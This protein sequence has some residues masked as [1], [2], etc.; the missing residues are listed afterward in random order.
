ML[1]FNTQPYFDDFDPS[2]NFHRILFKPGY[3]VQARELTQS[4]TIL[5]DQISKFADNIFSQNTPVTGGNVTTN[6]N[7]FYLK[8]NPIYGAV[9]IS[10]TAFLNR[11]IQNSTGTV[12]AKVIAATEATGG[13]P[14]TLVITYFTGKQFAAGD[15]IATA[16]G[17][18]LYANIAIDTG[19]NNPVGKSSTASISDGVFYVVN[20]YSI[21]NTQNAD[22]S[23]SQ[24]SIGNFVAVQ[25]QTIILD[26]YDSSPSLR[27]GLQITETVY[28]YVNDNSLLDPAVGA[29]NYQAPGA[30]RYVITLSLVT[31]PLTVGNDQGFIELVRIVNGQIVKQV[32]S[33][34]YSVID[35]YFAKRD[36]ETNGD[37]IVNDFKLT[38]Y[39]NTVNSNQYDLKIGKGIAYVRGYRI[40]NQSDYILTSDRA[41]TSATINTNPI[42][43]DYGNY[44]VVNNVSGVF[45]YTQMES[46]DLHCVPAENINSANANTYF[47]TYVGTGNIRNIQYVSDTLDSNT[48]S[49]VYNFFVDGVQTSI[50]SG[51]VGSATSTTITI[52]DVGDNFSAIANAYYGTTITTSLGDTRTIV[53]Y[54]G[55]TKTF[56]VNSPF[57][58]TPSTGSTFSLLFGTSNIDSIVI[59]NG[60][61]V[62]TS[63]ANIAL[64]G[65]TNGIST[66]ATIFENTNAPELLFVLGNPF[67][68]SVGSPSNYTSSKVFR[69]ISVSGGTTFSL[70]LP[71]TGPFTFLGTGVLS[72][73]VIKQNFTVVDTVTGNILDYSTSGNTVNVSTTTATFTSTYS[74]TNPVD[75]YSTVFV[76]DA[77]NGVV[78]K[79]KTL[80]TGNTVALG[81]SFVA[82]NSNT[83]VDLTAAQTQVKN[84]A[85]KSGKISLYVSDVK[86]ITK[87]IDT[88]GQSGSTLFT[89]SLY[90]VTN[91]YQLNNGQKD[92]YY[93]HAYIK[94]IPGAPNPSGDLIIVF[95]YY[96]HSGGDGYFSVN[97]YVNESYANIPSYTST[98]GTTYNLSDVLDFRP[99]RTNATT[100]STFL[101]SSQSNSS[102]TT[103]YGILIP[104]NLTEYISS[105]SYYLG[106]QD[107]LVLSK[108]KSFQIIEGAPSTN[109]ILPTEPNGSLVLADISL[110]PYTAYVPGENPPGVSPNLSI[111]KI[112]HYR[113]AK[114]DI[115]NLQSRVNNLEYYTSLN[116]LEQ[117]AQAL[118]VPD[119]NGLNR[120]KNGIL[121]DDFSSYL[122]ADSSNQDFASNINIRTQRLGPISVVENFQL[123]NPVVLG[124]LGTL[125][126]TNTYAISSISGTGTNIFTLPYTT[127]NVVVQ[128]LASSTVSLNPFSVTVYQGTA[129]LT[130]PMDNWVDNQQAPAIL[131]TDPTMQIYQQTNGVN[132]TNA[133]DFATIP[134]TTVSSASSYS[135]N[136]LNHGRFNGPFGSQ[137]GYT[138]TTTQTY[139]SSQALGNVTTTAGYSKVSSLV[140]NN[141]YITNIAVLPY[142]RP[143]QII[144][145]AKG[146]LLNA[147]VSTWFDGVNVD[148]YISSPDILE[149]T[150]VNGQFNDGDIIGFQDSLGN[151]NPVARVITAQITDPNV[152]GSSNGSTATNYSARLYVAKIPGAPLYTTATTVKNGYF[153]QNG[154]FTSST[155]YGTLNTTNGVS[156]IAS[157]GQVTGVGGSYSNTSGSNLQIYKVSYPNGWSSFMNQYAVWGD[158]NRSLSYNA[159]FT[160]VASETGTY[161]TY[162]A[163]DNGASFTIYNGATLISSFSTS[164]TYATVQTETVSLVAGQTYTINWAATNDAAFT[165]A[166]VALVLKSPSGNIDFASS[167][168]P[169]LSYT[170]IQSE[171]T[172]PL[173]GAYFTG[174]TSLKLDQ[175]ASNINNFYVGATINITT[176][177]VYDYT[178]QTASPVPPPPAP[179]GGSGSGGGSGC[180]VVATEMTINGYWNYAQLVNLNKWAIKNLDTNWIGNS[181]HKGYH[182]IAPK[183]II[184]LMK[185]SN[186]GKKYCEWSF[187]N[188]TNMLRGKKFNPLSIPN[189]LVW[190]TAMTLVGIFTRKESAERSWKSLYKRK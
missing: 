146:L 69:N 71:S 6:L 81:T 32:D 92:S 56:T 52:N 104:K 55:T 95:D 43:V 152:I 25:P 20:G 51:T 173:G 178:T 98:H 190:M 67:V 94:P 17:S 143:Q 177:L 127:A 154:N 87:I 64:T 133:G 91:L 174:V 65:K 90:D 166:G 153:D 119:S 61:Y 186:I 31:Y 164:Q 128:Q 102:Y 26:K 175:A 188:A 169:N 84:I 138:A 101:I 80:V 74:H 48:L 93:D 1:N 142:I 35:D 13:D 24:Y 123:Q 171:T 170:S 15:L 30:D 106:R 44:F 11:I 149:L 37:Y 111:N 40:E 85:T 113:W 45:D 27:V 70:S 158:L 156:N 47:S 59:Q 189:S 151:F 8:L 184:P 53:S 103:N 179:S 135:T 150:G 126:N 167:N 16:D 168:P 129:Q 147:N 181:L 137:V 183:I 116:L 125:S 41:R 122:T 140:T 160:F 18:N 5:Q 136:V 10:A 139:T 124:S 7:C 72:A 63:K 107:K 165:P 159:T 39:A 19:S 120:Y 162:C 89:D 68:S 157:S 83:N 76:N 79:T 12:L 2:K 75:V 62:V 155:A 114:S 60:S 148:Q 21:S 4:Q 23:Y 97:S 54:S 28:D 172:M 121:V 180:C 77:Q 50:L 78:L 110:D 176:K 109:P 145:K 130:P 144:V 33:T 99:A 131:I 29:S 86:K 38:P 46:V 118:Q 141:G 105:Y 115:T 182:I 134:G 49:Y 100:Q 96:S 82:V 132:I 9:N 3:A 185:N 161:T 187:E 14:P 163:A 22:G 36:Y 88:K 58:I 66:G 117:S 73:D 112:P 57:T 42:F 34:V 108:D